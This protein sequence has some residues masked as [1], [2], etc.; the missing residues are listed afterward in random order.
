MASTG[1]NDC[2]VNKQIFL[3]SILFL[4]LVAPSRSSSQRRTTG[5]LKPLYI[6]W[7][8]PAVLSAA[9]DGGPRHVLDADQGVSMGVSG[10]AC[11]SRSLAE[12]RL[13][14]RSQTTI[15]AVA[16]DGGVV[17][18]ADSRTSTGEREKRGD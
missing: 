4:L 17:L 1:L 2:D 10:L 5:V 15:M 11:S 7:T 14:V 18:G 8:F 6:L 12:T 16:Y 3:L 9:M 13:A